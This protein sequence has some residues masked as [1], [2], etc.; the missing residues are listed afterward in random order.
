[1]GIT[2]E[3]GRA[4]NNGHREWAV[5]YR[6]NQA[7]YGRFSGSTYWHIQHYRYIYNTSCTINLLVLDHQTFRKER[8]K[9]VVMNKVRNSTEKVLRSLKI[10]L[11][12]IGFSGVVQ[13]RQ[14]S[15]TLIQ[16][17]PNFCLFWKSQKRPFKSC[18]EKVWGREEG[19]GGIFLIW[20]V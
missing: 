13:W 3:L 20:R 5:R 14:A 18:T 7:K 11:W 6:R 4:N 1:M 16:K 10:F 19:G 15:K 9:N 12:Q 17:I 8:K 2:K